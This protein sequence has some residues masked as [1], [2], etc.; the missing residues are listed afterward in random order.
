MGQ[1]TAA[2]SRVITYKNIYPGIDLRYYT[3]NGKLKYDLIVHPGANPRN[4][5]LQYE[6]LDGLTVTNNRLLLKTSVGDVKEMEPYSYQAGEKGREEVRVKY[7]VSKDRVVRF[8]VSHFNNNRVLVI[9]PT[10]VFSTFTGSKAQLGIHC[11][12]RTG[13]NFFCRRNC[14][15]R[16]L[17]GFQ[18]ALLR[19]ISGEALLMWES[20]NSAA[21]AATDYMP[22]I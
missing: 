22:P 3:D 16:W 8:D 2:F 10:L 5:A 7:R 14:F 13:W 9:D 12:A 11:N 4:I 20:L 21:T 18:R 17:S 1:E 19:Q 6:G 15:R